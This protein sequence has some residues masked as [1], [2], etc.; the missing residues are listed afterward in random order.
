MEHWWNEE[1]QSPCHFIHHNF[2][3][4]QPWTKPGRGWQLTACA[5]H[6]SNPSSVPWG[7]VDSYS[8]VGHVGDSNI[9]G[10]HT[11]LRA[12]MTHAG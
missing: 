10:G 2:H 12:T 11:L 1:N 8:T 4:D 6:K 7:I 9:C 5:S 3:M